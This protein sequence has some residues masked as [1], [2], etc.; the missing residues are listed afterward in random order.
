[1]LINRKGL[2]YMVYGIS[3]IKKKFTIVL[4]ITN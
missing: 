1:M 2:W 3:V 4:K